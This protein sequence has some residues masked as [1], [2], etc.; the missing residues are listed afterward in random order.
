MYSK[1]FML[2]VRFSHHAKLRMIA[3]NISDEIIMDL[4]ENGLTKYK[5]EKHLWIYKAYANR[6]DNLFA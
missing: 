1:R 6:D 2:E 3:R 5:D 4:I